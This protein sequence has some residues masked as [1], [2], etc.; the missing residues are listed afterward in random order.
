MAF[1]RLDQTGKQDFPQLE[2]RHVVAVTA[3][4]DVRTTT[5]HIRGD[6][7]CTGTTCLSHD[8]RLALNIFGLGVEQV[9]GISAQPEE[10]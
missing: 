9:G 5:S 8:L 1:F 3:K 4:D 7:H 10:N 2:P 6:G